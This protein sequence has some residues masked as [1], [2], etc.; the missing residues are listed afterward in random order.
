MGYQLLG[1]VVLSA[2][3]VWGI[4]RDQR[5]VMQIGSAGALLF[6]FMRLVDWFWDLMPKWLFFL[7][8]GAVAL[9]ALLVLRRFR[10]ARVEA[11]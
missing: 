1:A 5:L 4:R 8:V 3:I 11:R 2:L 10:R 6:L 7:L 9:T